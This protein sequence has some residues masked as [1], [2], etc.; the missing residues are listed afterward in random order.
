MKSPAPVTQRQTPSLLS[1]PLPG[2]GA[3]SPVSLFPR[4]ENNRQKVSGGKGFAPCSGV[5]RRNEEKYVY[6]IFD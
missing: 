4:L 2:A 5:D 1:P 3:C 6:C